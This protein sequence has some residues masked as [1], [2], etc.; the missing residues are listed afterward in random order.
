MRAL[1]MNE[2]SC[3]ISS[4][5]RAT[6]FS[7]RNSD[8]RAFRAHR[9]LFCRFEFLTAAIIDL[10]GSRELSRTLL[11]PYGGAISSAD[12]AYTTALSPIGAVP[13]VCHY[14]LETLT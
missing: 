8:W 4:S 2:P 7:T 3:D 5:I 13:A 10:T 9:S 11:S 14:T 1:G 6:V 12:I